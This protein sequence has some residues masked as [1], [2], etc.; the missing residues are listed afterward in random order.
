MYINL[1]IRYWTF[2]T[3]ILNFM[4]VAWSHLHSNALAQKKRL[5]C[6]CRHNRDADV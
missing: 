4:N 6:A 5:T 2:L 1:K 3:L